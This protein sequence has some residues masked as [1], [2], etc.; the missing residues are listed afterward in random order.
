MEKYHK[1]Q[2]LFKRNPETKFKTLLDEYSL[3]EFEYLKNNNWIFTE[4]VDGTNIRIIYTCD[5][6]LI[7]GKT[8][9]AQLHCDLYDVLREK[10]TVEK[11]KKLF[12]FPVC[13]Y[14]EGYGSKIQKTGNNYKSDGMDFVLFDVNINN[15]WLERKNVEDIANKLNIDVVPIIGKGNLIAMVNMVRIGFNS[16]WGDFLAEG[17]VSRPEVELKTRSGERIITKLKYRDFYR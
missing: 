8:D 1:I 4:K 10:F 3:V 16:T 12:D 15:V 11:M 6:I 7:K 14:G 9:D 17:I 2:T 5:D 13:L